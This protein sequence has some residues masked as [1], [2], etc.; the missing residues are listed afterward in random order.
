MNRKD[1][2]SEMKNTLPLFRP[3]EDWVE[4]DLLYLIANDLGRYL[5]SAANENRL[6]ELAAAAALLERALDQ[7]DED[8]ADCIYDSLVKLYVCKSAELIRRYLGPATLSL[9]RT[10][11]DMG[12]R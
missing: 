2:I 6:D 4:D 9:W 3:P 8:V 12:W 5:C 11:D 10:R 1:F 7:G